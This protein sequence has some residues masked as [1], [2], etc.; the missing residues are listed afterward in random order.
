[1][2]IKII[3][4]PGSLGVRAR[5]RDDLDAGDR[6]ARSWIVEPPAS[7]GRMSNFE[8]DEWAAE[9]ALDRLA[10]EGINGLRAIAVDYLELREV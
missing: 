6:I 2:I 9:T 1:M 8:R 3:A 10:C 5:L 4:Q 7:W